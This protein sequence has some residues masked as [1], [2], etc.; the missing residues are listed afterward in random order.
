MAI[1]DP[2][3]RWEEIQAMGAHSVLIDG[4]PQPIN[5]QP[6]T[7]RI[8]LV[9]G[10]VNI[11]HPIDQPMLERI[12]RSRTVGFSTQNFHG[13]PIFLGFDGME[14]EGGRERLSGLRRTCSD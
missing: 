2:Q 6:S 3:G 14:F 1:F 13:A 12:A 9:N 11:L 8:R 10:W 5:Y 4:V 7:S